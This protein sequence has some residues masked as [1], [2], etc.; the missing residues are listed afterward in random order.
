MLAPESQ[1]LKLIKRPANIWQS[2]KVLK[3]NDINIS[4]TC[5]TLK[6]NPWVKIKLLHYEPLIQML[7]YKQYLNNSKFKGAS[8]APL[9]A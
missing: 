1:Q 2:L 9:P 5:K 3:E 8:W 7:K 4:D 6:A